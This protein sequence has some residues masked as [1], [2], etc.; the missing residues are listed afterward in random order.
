MS[1]D[2]VDGTTNIVPL[3]DE[4]LLIA[5]H[6][7]ILAAIYSPKNYYA[8]LKTFLSE[9]RRSKVEEGL[10]LQRLGAFLRSLFLIGIFGQE[11]RYY[12]KALAWSLFVRPSLFPH[13]VSFAIY[14]VHF[15]TIS[16]PQR[17]R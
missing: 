9:Y 7:K 3:M 13:T 1:G 15:R 8:R 6:Q 11:R 12:W 4:K 16:N 5:G 10:S 17:R 2:N 14:G